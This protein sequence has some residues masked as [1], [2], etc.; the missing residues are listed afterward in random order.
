[1]I[2]VQRFQKWWWPRARS[3]ACLHP[4]WLSTACLGREIQRLKDDVERLYQQ[5]DTPGRIWNAKFAVAA[6]D[7]LL[8]DWSKQSADFQ[9]GVSNFSTLHPDTQF[10]SEVQGSDAHLPKPHLLCDSI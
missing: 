6:V 3:S 2:C 5:E 1:M 7:A 9:A 4:G 8:E 10:F